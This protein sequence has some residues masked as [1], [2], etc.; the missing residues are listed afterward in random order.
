[1]VASCHQ[2]P[3]PLASLA[4]EFFIKFSIVYD[5]RTEAGNSIKVE[6]CLHDPR[7]ILDPTLTASLTASI[8]LK[9][10]GSWRDLTTVPDFAS[11]NKTAGRRGIWINLKK[12]RETLLL[13]LPLTRV[14][15]VRRMSRAI[16][17]EKQS[18]EES[19]MALS[20]NLLHNPLQSVRP[21]TTNCPDNKEVLQTKKYCQ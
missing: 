20:S 7:K 11:S 2:T 21:C 9:A 16:F 12:I 8:P 19:P 6:D 17:G 5:W 13:F 3:F 15:L 1:M 10:P 18:F 14:E 4:F